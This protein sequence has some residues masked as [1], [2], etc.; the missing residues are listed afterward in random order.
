MTRKTV[1]I[2]AVALTGLLIVATSAQAGD[3]VTTSVADLY[4]DKAALSGKRVGLQGE[5]VK[6]NN[7]IMRRNFVHV[8]DGSGDAA[9][10]T[11][12]LIVTTRDNVVVGDRVNVEGIVVL[13]RDFGYGYHYPL[14]VEE[15]SVTKKP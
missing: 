12:D 8:Q 5:V 14:L 3:A 6:V 7:G 10:G 2:L 13:D 9:D 4:R 15:A 1:S 11:N